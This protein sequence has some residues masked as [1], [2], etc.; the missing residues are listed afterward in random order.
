MWIFVKKMSSETRCQIIFAIFSQNLALE[1]K[2]IH[3]F[4]QSYTIGRLLLNVAQIYI[5]IVHDV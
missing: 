2:E 4:P 3:Q 1:L 5:R